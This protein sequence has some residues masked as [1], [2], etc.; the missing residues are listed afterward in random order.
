[1]ENVG[2]QAF[3]WE[4]YSYFLN[5]YENKSVSDKYSKLQCLWYNYIYEDFIIYL[6]QIGFLLYWATSRHSIIKTFLECQFMLF[7]IAMRHNCLHD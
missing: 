5:L 4:S 6:T 7:V 3:S 2:F 1:M